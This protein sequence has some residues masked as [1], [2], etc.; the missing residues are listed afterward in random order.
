MTIQKGEKVAVIGESGSGK[1]TLLNLIYGELEPS[2]GQ[3]TYAGH[4]LPKEH[5]RKVGSYILQSSHYF[6]GLSLEEN[7]CLGKDL[8][9]SKITW[10]LN[11]TGLVQLK[12]K[13]VSNQSLSGGE[14]QRLE[15]ARALY[16][17]SLF[18]LT[19]EVKANLDKE[20]NRKISELLF[21]IPQT[22]IEVIHHYSPEDLERYDQ[23]IELRSS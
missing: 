14:K 18:I 20:N 17:D 13:P 3:I 10:I 11:E 21:Q 6:D 8:D 5:I 19:D 9:A 12:D 23:V 15:I 1:T 4:S 16:H 7:I 2:Q 22:V